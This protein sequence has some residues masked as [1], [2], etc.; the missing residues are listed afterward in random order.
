MQH[1]GA[2]S[3][4]VLVAAL[5]AAALLSGCSGQSGSASTISVGRNPHLPQDE[6]DT[7]TYQDAQQDE[8]TIKARLTITLMGRTKLPGNTKTCIAEVGGTVQHMTGAKEPKS[9]VYVS[10][11]A[12]RNGHPRVTPNCP[13]GIAGLIAKSDYKRLVS[14][15]ATKA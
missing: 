2:R 8:L 1:L 10:Y 12:P 15:N 3:T 13:N 5:T 11:T 9:T 6:Q 7:T 4:T 14:Q